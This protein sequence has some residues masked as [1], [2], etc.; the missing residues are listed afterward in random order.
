MSVRGHREMPLEAMYTGYRKNVMA[1]DEVLAWIKVPLPTKDEFSRVYKISKRYDDDISAVCLAIRAQRSADGIAS[2]SMGV[3]GVAAT[4]VR[5][6]KTE[7]L[8]AGLTS[9]DALFGAIKQSLQAEFQPI[10]DMR[11]W[12]GLPA[13]SVAKAWS[14]WNPGMRCRRCWHERTRQTPLGCPANGRRPSWNKRGS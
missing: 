4:P 2:L 6:I 5:A 8:C 3:G 1:A 7:A 9:A 13:N 14:A 12:I 11:W 10:S